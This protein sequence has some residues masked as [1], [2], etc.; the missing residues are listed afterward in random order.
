VRKISAAGDRLTADAVGEVEEEEGVLVI[1]RIHVHMR[2]AAPDASTRIL[3]AQSLGALHSANALPALQRLGALQADGQ[4]TVAE[5]EPHLLAELAQPL[6]D[7]EGV[8]GQAPASLV[9]AVG[10]PEGDQIGIRSHVGPV[11][12]DV[13]A[14]IGDDGQ[15]TRGEDLEH[16]AGELGAAGAT[17]QHDDGSAHRPVILMP[18]LTLWRTLMEMMSGV[19]PSTMRAIS[20]GPQSTARSPSICPSSSATCVLSAR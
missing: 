19:R 18:A 13:I 20:S 17:R 4:V 15:L 12:L 2:L 8:A 5:V 11:D 16:A 9:D 10:E 7:L 1:R 14:T 3:A 6:H